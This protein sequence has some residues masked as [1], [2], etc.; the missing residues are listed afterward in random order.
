M[1]FVSKRTL[2]FWGIN[3]EIIDNNKNFVALI[4]IN[5]KPK[6]MTHPIPARGEFNDQSWWQW[7]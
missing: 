4:T 6:L 2:L 7:I 3:K 1:L 5:Y